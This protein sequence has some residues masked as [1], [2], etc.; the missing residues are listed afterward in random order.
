MKET[1]EQLFKWNRCLLG[2]G[3]DNALEYI[4]T[5]LGLDVIEIPSGTKVGMWEVPDE[6]IVR[7][8]WVKY[9]G[10][11]IL[12]YKKQPLSLVVGSLP[13]KGKVSWKELQK[14]I[15]TNEEQPEATPYWFKYYD[16]TWGFCAPHNQKFSDKGEYEVF[17]DTEYKPGVMKIGVHTIPG[18]SDREILLFA[19]LDHP[20]QANDNLSGVACLMDLATKIKAD[21]TIKII[22]L[23]ETIGSIAYGETQDISKVDFVMALDIVGNDKPILMQKTW[24]ADSRL[25]KVTGAAFQ[26]IG[27]AY[28]K[29]QFRTVIG[30]DEYFFNDPM[31]GIPGVMLSTH[32]YDQYHTADDTPDLINYDTIKKVQEIVQKTIEIWEKDYIPVRKPGVLMRSKYGL[33]MPSPQLNLNWDYFWYTLDGKKSLAEL[34]SDFEV[35]F[36]V[37]YEKFELMK[38][39][40]EISVRN[41]IEGEVK[42]TK[43]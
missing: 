6:W 43:E 35:N 7:D 26:V 11:K 21:H 41:F 12:D 31:I 13:F 27:G 17:I 4:N 3:Y 9:K 23:P 30:S 10:K 22:F 5:L 16:K 32:P 33:Q 14:H 42:E 39:D 40:N 25:N 28:R 29:G 38:K 1:I 8:A 36:D 19:H 37:V 15:S 20:F 2:E 34:C 18:K 24:D